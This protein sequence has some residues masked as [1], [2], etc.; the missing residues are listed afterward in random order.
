[1]E[2]KLW[3]DVQ[4]FDLVEE[5]ALNM[6]P[7]DKRESR[8]ILFEHFDLIEQKWNEMKRRQQP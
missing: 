3:V 1:M 7:S 8:K 6:D 5:F 4:G 2:C